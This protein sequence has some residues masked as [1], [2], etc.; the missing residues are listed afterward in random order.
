MKT[1]DQ[2]HPADYVAVNIRKLADNSYEFTQSEL[3]RQIIDGV[4]LGPNDT[5]K[6]IHMCSQLLL[7]HYWIRQRMTSLNSV[8]AR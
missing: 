5:T 8:T 6:P 2:G 1:E 7:H 4:G 3:M